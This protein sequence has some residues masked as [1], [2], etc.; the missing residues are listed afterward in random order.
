ML[1]PT[2]YEGFGFPAI[3]AQAA[4]V[5]VVFSPV[6]SLTELVGP[7]ALLADA[8]DLGAWCGAVQQAFAMAP[9]RASRAAA[10]RNWAQAFSW[11]QSFL[12]H[13]TVY[14]AAASTDHHSPAV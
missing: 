4:G 2:L 9:E 6:S 5:P 12:A 1:Y 14:A 7:L 11:Q 8:H 3:E 10:A 13:R